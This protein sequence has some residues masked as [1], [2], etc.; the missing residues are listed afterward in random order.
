M[1][2]L[3]QLELLTRRVV[4]LVTYE[5]IKSASNAGGSIRV[6]TGSPDKYPEMDAMIHAKVTPAYAHSFN[7][8]SPGISRT[9]AAAGFARPSTI[10]RCCGYPAFANPETTCSLPVR[11]VRE[12]S[13]ATAT[14]AVVV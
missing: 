8:A 3:C 4:G 1:R 5:T 13:S 2:L 14:I 9:I 10:R 6:C 12:P 11:Y 7:S